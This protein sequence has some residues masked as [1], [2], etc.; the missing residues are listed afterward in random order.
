M[1]V[2]GTVSPTPLERFTTTVPAS[3]DIVT[4]QALLE[5]GEMVVGEQDA[6]DKTGV[7][8][9][10]KVALCDEVPRV[11]VTDPVVSAEMLP[12][13]ALKPAVA[14]P[15][16][17]TTLG[18]TVIRPEFDPKETVVAV[19]TDCESVTVQALVTPD[20]TPLGLQTSDEIVTDDAAWKLAVRVVGAL[21]VT[22]VEALPALATEPPLQLWKAYPL[23]A[24]AV[25]GTG[26]PRYRNR[27][28][29]ASRFR[30]RPAT[31]PS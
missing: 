9:S 19:E 31:L 2:G 15:A 10:V 20:I 17:T 4:V 18:W 14:F 26:P 23:F 29:L 25:I 5:L 3:F 30:T 11:A 16:L 8:Q 12:I 24:V 22:V 27:R 28:S 7:D 1:T 21:S 6:A 13:L